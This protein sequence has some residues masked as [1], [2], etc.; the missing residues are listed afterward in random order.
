MEDTTQF[1]KRLHRW[2]A[3]EQTITR[4]QQLLKKKEID[5]VFVFGL[6]DIFWQL[7]AKKLV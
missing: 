1:L 5:G 7:F 2:Q 6:G 4:P 3:F